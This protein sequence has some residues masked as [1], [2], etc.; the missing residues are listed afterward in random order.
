MKVSG[1]SGEKLGSLLGDAVA[2]E[3]GR[4]HL[5]VHSSHSEPVQRFFN[6]LTR[7]TYIP[8]HIHN[9]EGGDETIVIL[10]GRCGVVIFNEST[11]EVDYIIELSS[12]DFSS[13]ALR[14]VVV[15]SGTAHTVICLSSDA[16]LFE[17][18]KGP[19]NPLSPKVYLSQFPVEGQAGYEQTLDSFRRLFDLT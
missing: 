1:V 18:K 7:G 6:F 19:F 4:A 17:V 8:P 12:E 5:N 13:K 10:R 9:E 3:R 2:S 14:C 11:G 15:P 16:L